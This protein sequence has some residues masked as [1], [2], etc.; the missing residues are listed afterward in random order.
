MCRSQ[1]PSLQRLFS[2][3]VYVLGRLAPEDGAVNA[4]I[5]TKNTSTVR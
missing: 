1:I 3:P 4:W 5:G 2:V